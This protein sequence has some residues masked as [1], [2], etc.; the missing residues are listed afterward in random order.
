MSQYELC[1][2]VILTE[3]MFTMM[4]HRSETTTQLAN[5]V[6][7]LRKPEFTPRDCGA[8]L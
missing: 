7:S 2:E 3:L 4:G 6:S 1:A 8:H 5:E